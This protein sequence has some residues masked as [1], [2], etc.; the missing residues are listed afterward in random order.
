MGRKKVELNGIFVP[1]NEEERMGGGK[2]KEESR[3]PKVGR[4]VME[5]RKGQRETKTPYLYYST[6][7]LIFKRELS[8]SQT[9]RVD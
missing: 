7:V 1:R 5:Q 3:K 8:L 6:H 2:K 9:R 4:G